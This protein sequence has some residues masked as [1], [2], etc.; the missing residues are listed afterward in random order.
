M[1]SHRG[2]VNRTTADWHNRSVTLS[3]A[4]GLGVRF[5]AALRMTRVSGRVVECMNVMW[6]DLGI[7]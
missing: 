2:E 5:F 1:L 4:K 3:A 7:G 6:F